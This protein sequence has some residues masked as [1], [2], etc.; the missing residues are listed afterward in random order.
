MSRPSMDGSS[1]DRSSLRGDEM[2]PGESVAK[3]LGGKERKSVKEA[4]FGVLFTLS[5]EK[6]NTSWKFALADVF[7]NWIQLM[8]LVLSGV[9]PWDLGG[10]GKVANDLGVP[11]LLRSGGYDVFCAVFY[12]LFAVLAFSLSLCIYVAQNFLTDRF[13]YVWPIKVLRFVVSIFFRTFYIT[14]L[15]VFAVGPDCRSVDGKLVSD[16]FPDKECI[17]F[18]HG[19]A[20]VLAVLAGVAG[21]VIS[22]LMSVAES[23]LDPMSEELIGSPDSVADVR[24]FSII[25]VITVLSVFLDHNIKAFSIVMLIASLAFMYLLYRKVPYY[26]KWINALQAGLY[27]TLLWTSVCLVLVVFLP[28]N[29]TPLTQTMYGGFVPAFFFFAGMMVLR[30]RMF[31]KVSRL[32]HEQGEAASHAFVDE[33]SVEMASRCM[34]WRDQYGNVQDEWV[35]ASDTIIRAGMEQFPNNSYLTLLYSNFLANAR[36]SPGAS[37]AQLANA[38]R[39]ASTMPMGEQFQLFVRDRETKQRDKGG[40]AGATM[41]LVSYVEFQNN[42][43]NL[44]AWHTGALQS[45]RNFWRNLLRTDLTFRTLSRSFESL[46]MSAD[47]AEKAYKSM[48]ERYPKN[49]KLLRSYGKFCE[50]LKNDPWRAARYYGEADKIE[51]IQAEAQRDAVFGAGMDEG[52]AANSRVD[53][54]QDAVVVISDT[55]IIQMANRIMNKMFGYKV[56]ELEG[57][58]VSALMP[59]PF[60]GQHNSFLRNYKL[61]GRSKVIGK[62]REVIGLHSDGSVMPLRLAVSKAPQA[63]A[64]DSFMGVLRPVE[65]DLSCGTAWIMANG[66]ILATNRGFADNFGYGPR[67]TVGKSIYVFSDANSDW[68]SELSRIADAAAGIGDDDDA[69]LNAARFEFTAGIQHKYAGL[70]VPAKVVVTLAGTRAQR[71]LVVHLYPQQTK[72]GILVFNQLG[73]CVYANASAEA[74]IEYKPGTLVRNE[75]KISKILPEPYGQIHM[76]CLRRLGQLSATT[77]PCFSGRPT[78]LKGKN[79]KNVPVTLKWKPMRDGEHSVLVAV[80]SKLPALPTGLWTSGSWDEPINRPMRLRLLVTEEGE[81]AAGFGGQGYQFKVPGAVLGVNEADLRGESLHNYIDVV[82][83]AVKN[84][85]LYGD[86]DPKS[87]VGPFLRNLLRKSQEL[88][89]LAWRMTFLPEGSLEPT[90]LGV[91]GINVCMTVKRVGESSVA[92]NQLEDLS[93]DHAT[94]LS[95]GRGYCID[96]W[97][98]DLLEGVIQAD[99]GF[100]IRGANLHA[101]LLFGWHSS[102]MFGKPVD[103]LLPQ[104]ASS[105]GPIRAAATGQRVANAELAHADG[106]RLTCSVD[107]APKSASKRKFGVLVR[108]GPQPGDTMDAAVCLR[109]IEALFAKEGAARMTD[110][111]NA[112][113]PRAGGGVRFAENLEERFSIAASSMAEDAGEPADDDDAELAEEED[114]RDNAL[115]EVDNASEGGE[116]SAASSAEEEE[117]EAALA[118]DFRRAKRFQRLNRL[119]RNSRVKYLSMLLR[120]RAKQLLL[121]LLVVTVALFATTMAVAE[122]YKGSFLLVLDAVKIGEQIEFM[123]TYSKA[124]QANADGEG[125]VGQDDVRDQYRGRL[126]DAI[127][128]FNSRAR[129]AYVEPRLR[130]E[131]IQDVKDVFEVPS[132]PVVFYTDENVDPQGDPYDPNLPL[133]TNTTRTLGYLGLYQLYLS[134]AAQVLYPGPR[135]ASTSGGS[136]GAV[137]MSKSIYFNF[138]QENVHKG[139]ESG[140][141]EFED[142]Q[143]Q[144][145]NA[146]K[147][148]VQTVLLVSAVVIGVALVPFVAISLLVLTL[149]LSGSRGKLLGIFLAVPRPVLIGLA[150]RDLDLEDVEEGED[151]DAWQRSTLTDVEKRQM[152]QQRSKQKKKRRASGP[153]GVALNFLR[154]SRELKVSNWRN[155]LKVC[156]PMVGLGALHLG[157]HLGARDMLDTIDSNTSGMIFAEDMLKSAARVIHEAQE[158]VLLDPTEPGTD[159]PGGPRFE[160]RKGM[161]A[162]ILA[163]EASFDD[164]VFGNSARGLDGNI[165]GSAEFHDLLFGTDTCL[166]SNETACLTK[167]HPYYDQ[168]N[169]G[170]DVAVREFVQAAK[171][172][173]TSPLLETDPNERLANPLFAF[174]IEAEYF[175][176][177]GGLDKLSV[178]FEKRAEDQVLLVEVLEGLLVAITIVWVLAYHRLLAPYTQ[179]ADEE[180]IYAS[181]LFSQLPEEMNVVEHIVT[182]AEMETTGGVGVQEPLRA[183]IVRRVKYAAVRAALGTELYAE[184][185][186][187]IR[188]KEVEMAEAEANELLGLGARWAPSS[189]APTGKYGRKPAKVTVK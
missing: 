39:L 79:S 161:N 33:W 145:L 188:A 20:A 46:A 52:D 64:A 67:E 142:A 27:G 77:A 113:A 71:I 56:G 174:L 171:L 131:L 166:R 62:V 26:N 107:G 156:L 81:I 84:A 151:K 55:G 3:R 31:E 180:L 189:A 72:D 116:S 118:A 60:S 51:D 15:N 100:V 40:G 182:I 23:S 75:A 49:V 165:V 85:Q 53:D 152:A 86:I 162:S 160:E 19:L 12:I 178:T 18:P 5:K 106:G 43:T 94:E 36:K 176:I 93:P 139:M 169:N 117:A 66:T 119:L 45:V 150:A 175:D 25:T 87:V 184:V 59:Q 102:A 140:F 177:R 24:F 127:D 148:I 126:A 121:G 111:G 73:E 170:L 185:V 98:T 123:V 120:R 30:I 137:P 22:F 164:I 28:E 138:V 146:R 29:N 154:T 110:A 83:A 6:Y 157:L 104:G 91:L 57:M 89:L 129:A 90:A 41:D 173:D 186:E 69:A 155:I 7:L 34:R 42:F 143:K 68:D 11:E 112:G 80:V 74:I 1:M 58:N 153:M 61:T 38:K 125:Y 114:D 105:A 130:K 4:V 14:V 2:A 21:G 10:F 50:D 32:Y 65:D 136:G 92:V 13:P 109:R 101:Q 135:I 147:Q 9:F 132:L 97:R 108:A 8:L 96:L 44:L 103:H 167:D 99:K 179:L 141:F 48:L 149:K 163:F 37:L 134:S 76:R 187:D 168:L 17:G 183:R 82:A 88:G 47:R 124:L 181:E 159:L 158:L 70:D 144:D 78:V 128:A 115:V 54:T 16:L 122:S 172:L 63:D 35:D 133:L 95:A